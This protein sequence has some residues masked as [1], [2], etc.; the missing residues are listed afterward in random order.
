MSASSYTV[1][2]NP[3]Y[4]SQQYGTT[5]DLIGL[6]P[7]NYIG[8]I[9]SNVGTAAMLVTRGG[10][11]AFNQPGRGENWNITQA[12]AAADKSAWTDYSW[13]PV[14]INDPQAVKWI[15]QHYPDTYHEWLSKGKI[16]ANCIVPVMST[17]Q[18]PLE[19]PAPIVGDTPYMGT[20]PAGL[21]A[22]SGSLT[23]NHVISAPLTNQTQIQAAE[24][25]AAKAASMGTP[26][27]A[28]PAE[29]NPATQGMQTQTQTS[30]TPGTTQSLSD[31]ISQYNVK[32]WTLIIFAGAIIAAAVWLSRKF[33][34][35]KKVI[36]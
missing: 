22:V 28:T 14:T 16:P 2:R 4:I 10:S 34:H 17:P 12:F 1:S 5:L 29:S 11:Y 31:I 23:A 3:E 19:P 24:Q 25:S 18:T 33:R 35:K 7:D 20:Q 27:A 15:Y 36:A 30:E 26:T 13:F 9:I 6:T 21:P 32:P 8:Q